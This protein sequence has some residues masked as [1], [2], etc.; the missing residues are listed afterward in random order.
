[1][2]SLGL[3][4]QTKSGW[5][6]SMGFVLAASVDRLFDKGLISFADDGLI[7]VSNQLTDD[8][9]HALNLSR[10]TRLAKISDRHRVYLRAHRELKFKVE[11]P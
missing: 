6:H 5:I 9:L 11:M 10:A 8:Q 3:I 7:M 2:Q 4:V 1:M